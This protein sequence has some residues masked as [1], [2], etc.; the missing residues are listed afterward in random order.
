MN[1][2]NNRRTVLR[3]I[4]AGA[5]FGPTI[6]HSAN[7]P[8]IKV[9]KSAGCGCCEAWIDHLKANGFAV[10]AHDVPSPGDFRQKGVIPDAL[11]ACHTAQ[12]KGYTIEGHVPAADIKRLL[13]SQSKARG[14]AVPSMPLGSPGMEGARK[15]PYDVFLVDSNGGKSVYR[16]YDG[17]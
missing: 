17:Q 12:V 15:V 10:E 6:G 11:G 2:S 7:Q 13:A 8:Q 5:I 3:A 9:F 4:L 1:Q 14:L 16:H